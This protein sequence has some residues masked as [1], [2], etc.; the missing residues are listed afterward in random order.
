MLHVNTARFIQ[1][2]LKNLVNQ[3]NQIFS[4]TPYIMLPFDNS[5]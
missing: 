3:L 5:K 4:S 2:V 1:N